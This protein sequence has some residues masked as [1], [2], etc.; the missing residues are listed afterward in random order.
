M[1]SSQGI[2]PKVVVFTSV[3]LHHIYLL[4]S[5][6]VSSKVYTTNNDVHIDNN[7]ENCHY[8]GYAGEQWRNGAKNLPKMK[9]NSARLTAQQAK[10]GVLVKN[11]F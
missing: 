11:L 1:G 10:S 6:G 3:Y 2:N 8:L 9:E 5:Q 4:R 7:H